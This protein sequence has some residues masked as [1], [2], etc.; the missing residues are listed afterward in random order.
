MDIKTTTTAIVTAIVA[1]IIVVTVA[2][3]IL[4]NVGEQVRS[5]ELN[6]APRFYANNSIDSSITY[7]TDATGNVLVNGEKLMNV[8]VGSLTADIVVADTFIV[9]HGGQ[10][11][12]ELELWIDEPTGIQKI[13]LNPDNTYT[14]VKTDSSE[15][16]GSFTT[17]IYADNKGDYVCKTGTLISVGLAHGATAYVCGNAY[18]GSNYIRTYAI[19]DNAVTEIYSYNTSPVTYDPTPTIKE[20]M[21]LSN[22]VEFSGAATFGSTQDTFFLNVFVP[23]AYPVISAQDNAIM[24]MIHII[25]LLMIVGLIVAV[26]AMFIRKY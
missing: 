8:D 9:R 13:T 3:P 16:T 26:V 11:I 23:A 12:S 19:E 18:V 20:E 10:N 6:D 25:P 2:V 22:I 17:I 7:S 1:L 24:S 14:A 4:T 15:I 21:E 5:V